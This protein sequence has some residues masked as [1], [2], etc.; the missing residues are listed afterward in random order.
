MTNITKISDSKGDLSNDSKKIAD[1]LEEYARQ[2]RSGELVCN[3]CVVG[4]ADF[5]D[6]EQFYLT[7]F[8]WG[9]A[10]NRNLVL[11]HIKVSVL[12]DTGAFRGT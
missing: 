11:D 9:R 2:I 7:E 10:T 6:I 3:V 1:A 4:L 5:T 8:S 12:S